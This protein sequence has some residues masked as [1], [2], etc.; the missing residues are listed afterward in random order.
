M[1]DM[2]GQVIALIAKDGPFIV[3]TVVF[4]WVIVKLFLLYD[5]RMNEAASRERA[6]A[7]AALDREQK[8]HVSDVGYERQLRQDERDG[9]IAA[10]HRLES[11]TAALREATIGFTSA[12]GLLERQSEVE[13][14]ART[15]PRTARRS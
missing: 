11:N 4:G 6:D 13:D 8:A 7:A 2:V 5:K 3:L 10:E 14:V 15:A 9:R 1:E 12:M